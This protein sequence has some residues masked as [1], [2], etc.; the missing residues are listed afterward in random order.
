MALQR[1]L[2]CSVPTVWHHML[3]GLARHRS[4]LDMRLLLQQQHMH[5]QARVAPEHLHLLMLRA[6]PSC[7][8]V[9]CGSPV[10]PY[11]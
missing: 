5:R 8:Q 1:H 10:Q 9:E 11:K 2:G 4:T 6:P 3:A 7:C